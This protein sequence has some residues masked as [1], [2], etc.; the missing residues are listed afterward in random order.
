MKPQSSSSSASDSARG[1]PSTYELR[2]SQKKFQRLIEDQIAKWTPIV[3][4]LGI[5]ID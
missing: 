3:T 1:R 2:S 4:S 5:K